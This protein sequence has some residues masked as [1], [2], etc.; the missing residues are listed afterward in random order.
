MTIA[1]IGS[2]TLA[3]LLDGTIIFVALVLIGL[4]GFRTVEI[5]SLF[6]QGLLS[7]TIIFLPFAYLVAFETLNGGRTPGKAAAGIKVVQ[8]S[9]APVG[10][11]G[12]VIRTLLLPIDV[13]LLGVGIVS[14]FVT[15]RSQR[16]GDIA[17]RTVVVRD[18]ER[19]VPVSAVASTTEGR[20][21]DQHP[22][23][24]VSSVT[25]QEIGAIRSFLGRAQGL[26]SDTRAR[27]AAQL[28]QRLE[29]RIVSTGAPLPDEAFLAR[30][31]AEKSRD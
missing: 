10:F 4:I 31:L 14:A 20:P 28:R 19:V 23:W 18:R 6:T 27:Y 21:I 16:L 2:R 22:R 13:L 17:A 12:A 15:K 9:G 25:E 24:D 1:G 3:W 7:V 30:V 5:D 26:P 8:V 11:G 29:P